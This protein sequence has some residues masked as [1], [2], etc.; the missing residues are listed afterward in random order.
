MMPQDF[1]DDPSSR[2]FTNGS[3]KDK[4]ASVNEA[5][6]FCKVTIFGGPSMS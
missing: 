2:S 3:S 5:G 6:V 4:I 1:L